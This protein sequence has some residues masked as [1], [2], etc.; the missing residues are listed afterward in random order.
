MDQQYTLTQTVLPSNDEETIGAASY[1]IGGGKHYVT[2]EIEN[3]DVAVKDTLTLLRVQKRTVETGDLWHNHLSTETQDDFQ[4][5]VSSSSE[6]VVELST[7]NAAGANIVRSVGALQA[8]EKTVFVMTI[9]STDA[10]RIRAKSLAASTVNV[11]VY[12]GKA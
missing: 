4:V 1:A 10:I 7:F 12:V 11:T 9:F 5:A 8:G 6:K 2:V 3:E